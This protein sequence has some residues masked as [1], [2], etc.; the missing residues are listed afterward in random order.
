VSWVNRFDFSFQILTAGLPLVSLWRTI[1]RRS[2]ADHISN[3]AYIGLKPSIS[4]LSVEKLP[5]STTK[6]FPRFLFILTWRLPN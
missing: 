2:A 1:I 3:V 5:R 6:Y 4:K